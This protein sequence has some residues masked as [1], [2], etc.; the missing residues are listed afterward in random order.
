MDG[1]SVYAGLPR[2]LRPPLLAGSVTARG[3]TIG[4]TFDLSPAV[5]AAA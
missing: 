4:V 3:E 1:Y 5:T 2:S